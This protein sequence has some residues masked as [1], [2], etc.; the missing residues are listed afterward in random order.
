MCRVLQRGERVEAV[1]AHAR[2]QAVKRDDAALVGDVITQQR[3]AVVVGIL[4][5]L[6]V[7]AVVSARTETIKKNNINVK[8]MP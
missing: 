6:C 8:T 1:G 4:Y 7:E 5:T 2:E 3:H